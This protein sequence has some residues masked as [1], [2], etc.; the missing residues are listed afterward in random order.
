VEKKPSLEQKKKYVWVEN[1]YNVDKVYQDTAQFAGI[2]LNDIDY[3][4]RFDM[5]DNSQRIKAIS[6]YQ[7]IIS[8]SVYTGTSL[9]QLWRILETIGRYEI[10][11]LNYYSLTGEWLSEAL[12][13]D[14]GFKPAINLRHVIKAVANNNL[15]EVT[16]SG[17]KK[18]VFDINDAKFKAIDL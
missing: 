5:L 6:D 8:C 7:G 16:F 2:D 11:N 15:Y 4:Y 9:A 12:N 1:D 17:K 14:T 13:R 18:V 10:N 3:L